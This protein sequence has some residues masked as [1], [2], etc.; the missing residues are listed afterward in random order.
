MKKT[1]KGLP[2]I[3]TASN[4]ADLWNIQRLFVHFDNRKGYLKI[5]D[6]GEITIGPTVDRSS[7]HERTY[8]V[9]V[10]LFKS[11]EL[12]HDLKIEDPD[13]WITTRLPGQHL[14]TTTR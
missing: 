11:W 6:S 5:S 13:K 7:N 14:H 10:D 1:G 2:M 3:N 8:R 9:V 4:P 12:F